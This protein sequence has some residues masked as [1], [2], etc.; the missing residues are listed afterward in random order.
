MTFQDFISRFEKQKKTPRG[1]MVQCPAHEDGSP[2]LSISEGKEGQILLKCFGGCNVNS[3]ISSLGLRLIDLFPTEPAKQF[4]PPSRPTVS[5][6]DDKTKGE[7]PVIEKIYSYQN[8][9]G[10]EVYQAIRMKP[11]SFR[12]RHMVDGEWVWK[13][14][15]VDRVLFQLPKVLEAKEVWIVE[16]E[17]DAENLTSLGFV[18]T[19]N[20]GGAG[21]W[22]DGYSESLRDKNVVICGDNDE[23]GKKHVELVFDSIAGIAKTVRIVKLP[24]TVKDASDHI[25]TFKATDEAKKSFEE[26]RDQSHP[27]IK[28]FKMPL[29]TMSDLERGYQRHAMAIDKNSFNLGKWLPSL[30]HIRP[31]VAGELVFILGDT[32]AGKTGLLQGICKAAR[33]LPTVMFEL[34]LP[35]ELL[36]ERFAAD[37][38]NM[39][40]EQVE[41]AYKTGDM[42]GEALDKKFNNLL[43][44]TESRMTLETLESYIRR[45]ELKMGEMPKLV[46]VDYIQL[47]Q[48]TGSN[49]R[50]RVSDIAEGLKVL[51]KAT[52][53]IIIVTSQVRRPDE[54][55]NE[56][57][58]LHSAKESGSIENSCGLLLGAWRDR[59]DAG[60]LHLRVLKSTK[61]GSGLTVQC[62]FD[63]AKMRITERA[64]TPISE[65]DV[66]KPY[67][68]N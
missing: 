56:G 2:S 68:E 38:A 5:K 3:I 36:F 49:R 52:K 22:L 7:K 33:P 47:M 53:T 13:M 16:G 11:K 57:P 44:C 24:E 31:L 18:A 20:V 61:G 42:L 62:N 28:G 32:G 46:L 41:A 12:Q 37:A 48:S 4:T 10:D 23:P 19:C 39:T 66:P 59:E 45:S 67:N 40:C 14:D 58:T 6:N 30:G 15:G 29:Y 17:K 50:E 54:D 35:P 60:L 26:M 25:Q 8:H 64:K 34:E 63:G 65:S 1:V 21:K 27:F 43:I 55:D 51:A 9:R